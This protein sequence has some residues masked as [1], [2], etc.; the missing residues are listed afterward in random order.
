MTEPT[1]RSGPGTPGSVPGLVLLGRV[2]PGLVL[3]E[4]VTLVLPLRPVLLLAPPRN[5][6]R[7]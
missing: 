7:R 5:P 6:M 3:P 1:G 4:M 2:L